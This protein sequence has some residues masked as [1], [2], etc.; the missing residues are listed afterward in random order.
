MTIHKLVSLLAVLSIVLSLQFPTARAQEEQ[1]QQQEAP[2]TLDDLSG[3]AGTWKATIDSGGEELVQYSVYRVREDLNALTQ[4]ILTVNPETKVV[5]R[6]GFGFIGIPR[7]TNQIQGLYFESTGLWAET[8]GTLTDNGLLLEG[9]GTLPNARRLAAT[10]EYEFGEDQLKVKWSN[11]VSPQG[12]NTEGY[13]VVNSRLDYASGRELARG[14]GL[15][16][17]NR[18]NS[19]DESLSPLQNLLGNWNAEEGHNL[20][21][22][23]RASGRWIQESWQLPNGLAGLNVSGLDPTTGQLT[24]WAAGRNMIGRT[25]YW[26]VLDDNVLAQTQVASRLVRKFMD[27]DEGVSFSARWEALEDGKFVETENGYTATRRQRDRGAEAS[28]VAANMGE[29]KLFARIEY[30]SVP[31]GGDDAYLE[32][33]KVWK[34][35]HQ[36][37]KDAGLISQWMVFKVERE[38]AAEDDYQYAVVH[39]TDSLENF[40]SGNFREFLAAANL[41]E[42]EAAMVRKTADTRE[43]LKNDLWGMVDAVDLERIGK[44]GSHRTLRIGQM[45]STNEAKHWELEHDM[46]KRVWAKKVADGEL[47]NWLL[48]HRRTGEGPNFVAVHVFPE[49]GEAQAPRLSREE[50]AATFPELSTDELGAKLGSTGRVRQMVSVENWTMVQGLNAPE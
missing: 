7:R 45:Q 8:I 4:T 12:R 24:L 28:N 26:N 21:W 13:E 38:N 32:V 50:M 36:A 27:S 23:P 10:L 6:S 48:F 11:L 31:E 29:P 39:L 34:K 46:W 30:M 42:E 19:L 20:S 16:P 37:R 14:E 43:M 49:D 25:G 47:W 9:F 3:L 17:S 44:P 5:E 15:Q 40:G 18:G 22:R 35:I 1:G 33:E 2:P 41:S